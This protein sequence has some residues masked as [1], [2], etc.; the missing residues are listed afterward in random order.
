MASIGERKSY[1]GILA[2]TCLLIITICGCT[3]GRVYRG[4]ELRGDPRER[5][6]IGTTKKAE[7]LRIFGPPDWIQKQF[8]GDIFVYAY[9]RKNSSTLTLEEPVFTNITFFTYRRIQEK[10]DSLVILFGKHGVVK[11]YGHYR[12]TTELKP[13]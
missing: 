11:D 8:D 1:S 3:I 2:V 6:V 4:S 13:L 12:G 10:R 9:L 7:I 5:I